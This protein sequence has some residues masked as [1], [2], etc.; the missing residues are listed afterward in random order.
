VRYSLNRLD[1]IRPDLFTVLPCVTT[2]IAIAI[3]SLACAC[4]SSSPP[5]IP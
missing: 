4:S 2:A 3:S 5:L 1:S